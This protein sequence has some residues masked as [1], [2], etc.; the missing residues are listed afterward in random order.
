MKTS[1]LLPADTA[2]ALSLAELRDNAASGIV[3]RTILQ[4]PEL[5][6]VH[7]VFDAGQE[8]TAHA[9]PHRA[10]VQVLEGACEFLFN[11]QWQRLDAGALLHLPPAHPHAVRAAFGA[12]AMLLTLGMGG[13]AA[14][15]DKKVSRGEGHI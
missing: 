9:S 11:E 1:T 14:D 5:R 12:F 4:S 2:Q 15:A 6:V 10:V 7:F 13:G 8:L 3:S